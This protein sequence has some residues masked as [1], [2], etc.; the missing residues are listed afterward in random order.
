MKER[1]AIV[2]FCSHKANEMMI[3]SPKLVLLRLLQDDC[4]VGGDGPLPAWFWPSPRYKLMSAPLDK[5]DGTKASDFT[6][7]LL[8]LLNHGA[9]LTAMEEDPHPQK[10]GEGEADKKDPG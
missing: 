9:D 5:H 1:R 2:C 10:H 3:T 4:G 8:S 7:E 6:A